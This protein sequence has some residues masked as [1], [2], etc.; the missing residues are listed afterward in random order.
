MPPSTLNFHTHLKCFAVAPSLPL[1]TNYTLT[2]LKIK[3]FL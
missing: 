2:N 1:E 3:S